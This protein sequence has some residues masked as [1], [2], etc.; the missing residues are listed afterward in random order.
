MK[1]KNETEGQPQVGSDAGLAVGD[2][3]TWCRVTQKGKGFNLSTKEGKVVAI[4]WTM[5]TVKMRNGR[6]ETLPVAK[7]RKEGQTT[8]LTEAVM[9]MRDAANGGCCAD[10][11]G[12]HPR[13]WL[14]Q[15]YAL[16]TSALAAS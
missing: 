14:W 4:L 10:S 16:A 15:R 3:V 11:V 2:R 13:L 12:F 8:E 6:T 5:A 1:T 7:L 9:G